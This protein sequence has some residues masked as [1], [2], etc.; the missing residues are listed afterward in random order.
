MHGGDYAKEQYE[1][2]M[3]FWASDKFLDSRGLSVDHLRQ[4]TQLQD[5]SH[6]NILHTVLD[7]L[8]IESS[9]VDKNMSLC[10]R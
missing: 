2:P 7:C 4:L 10:S 9:M 6:D 3:I 5:I 8:K 1:I